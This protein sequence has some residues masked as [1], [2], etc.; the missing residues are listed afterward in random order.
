MKEAEPGTEQAGVW[1][2]RLGRQQAG[3]AWLGCEAN[4]RA[5]RGRECLLAQREF[6]VARP[7]LSTLCTTLWWPLVSE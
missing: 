6:R 4:G 3:K 7:L 2:G 5:G 1:S